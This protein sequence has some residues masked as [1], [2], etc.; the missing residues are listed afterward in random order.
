M[1]IDK[2]YYRILSMALSRKIILDHNVSDESLIQ[3]LDAV[4][5]SKVF[6]LEKLGLDPVQSPDWLIKKKLKS[7]GSKKSG[8]LFITKNCKH[9]KDPN[10]YAV[11]CVPDKIKVK[12][13]VES[14]RIWLAPL[15]KNPKNRVYYANKTSKKDSTAYE[16]G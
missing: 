10:G 16:I 4:G 2:V 3:G 8:F 6:T 13:F 15:P 14:V 7:L 5:I 11:L 12:D 9:F 1:L